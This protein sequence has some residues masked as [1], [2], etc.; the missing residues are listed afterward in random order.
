MET[1]KRSIV[2][3]ISWRILASFATF[4][5]SYFLT[6]DI[7]VATGIASVQIVVNLILYYLHER[8][9]NKIKWGRENV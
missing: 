1:N 8:A 2:K 6:G 4:L 9:W 3:A 5:I 7:T